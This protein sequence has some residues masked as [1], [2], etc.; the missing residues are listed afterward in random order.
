L[1][2][3]AKK[4]GE[5]M[6]VID[7]NKREKEILRSLIH[8]YLMNAEAVSS[9]SLVQHFKLGISS[10]TVRNIFAGL[11][12]KGY[13]K[14]PYTSAGRVPSDIGYRF[15]VDNLMDLR[16]LT[17][18]EEERIDREYFS[19]KREFKFIMQQTSLALSKLTNYTGIVSFPVLK[20]SSL[21]EVKLVKLDEYR[22][23]VIAVFFNGM[24]KDKIVNLDMFIEDNDVEIIKTC[25]NLYVKGK[26]VEDIKSV[27]FI[28][29]AFVNSQKCFEIFIEIIESGIFD[30]DENEMHFEGWRN[31]VE[32][33]EFKDYEKLSRFLSVLDGKTKLNDIV[34]DSLTRDGVNIYI[35][36][37]EKGLEDCSVITA[38]YN[39]GGEKS[40]VIGVIGPKRMMYGRAVSSVEYLSKQVSKY[41]TGLFRR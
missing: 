26:A 36:K 28:Q 6:V 7:L 34:K 1:A 27:L 16:R 8:S 23:V 22:M 2:K 15:Y 24:V 3:T 5:R 33:P 41:L 17:K 35:G 31:L 12:E 32:Y 13:I 4:K 30:F 38:S 14:Q 19:K 20:Q 21:K 39:V 37:D 11:E 9:K 25:L 40:G 18:K 29:D 10:A